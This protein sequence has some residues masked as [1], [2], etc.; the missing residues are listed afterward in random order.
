MV[1]LIREFLGLL[2][3]PE[4]IPQRPSQFVK[5][6]ITDRAL[7]KSNKDMTLGDFAFIGINKARID[8]RCHHWVNDLYS[9]L[10]NGYVLAGKKL[11]AMSLTNK[12]LR[13][14]RVMDPVFG[15]PSADLDVLSMAGFFHTFI[16]H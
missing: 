2:L 6:D 1:Q 15:G 12:T 3:K 9:K 10:R 7:Q 5:L 16:H 11:L 14:L 13:L 8:K 4:N